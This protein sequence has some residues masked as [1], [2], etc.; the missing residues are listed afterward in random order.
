MVL[1]VLARIIRLLT[2]GQADV[3]QACDISQAPIYNKRLSSWR[4][5]R[6]LETQAPADVDTEKAYQITNRDLMGGL[7]L[8]RR[9]ESRA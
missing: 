7:P 1:D 5:R 6:A 8:S 2:L 9:C 4:L 3:L